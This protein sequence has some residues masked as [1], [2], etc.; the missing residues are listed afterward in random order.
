[1]KRKYEH[2][3]CIFDPV[4]VA[5]KMAEKKIFSRQELS[6]KCWVGIITTGR[7]VNGKPVALYIAIKIA[8]LLNIDLQKCTQLIESNSSEM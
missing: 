3:M 1:M 7:A 8:S 4:E 6:D 2:R 5:Q